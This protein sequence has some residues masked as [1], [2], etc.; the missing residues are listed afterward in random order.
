M[1]YFRLLIYILIV[2]LVMETGILIYLLF[3][4]T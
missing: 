1:N 3:E 2:F 4:I